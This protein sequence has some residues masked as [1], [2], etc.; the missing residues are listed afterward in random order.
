MIMKKSKFLT[1]VFSMLPGA[2]HMYIG[3]MKTG[4]SFMAAFFFLIFL[5]SWL[6]IGPLLFVL[7]LIW[8]YSFFD[9]ANRASLDDDKLLLLEDKYLFSLDKLVKLDKDIFEKRRLATGVLLLLLGVYLVADNIMNI[10]RQYIPNELYS[11]MNQFMRQ[12]PQVIIGVAI[13]ALGVKLIQGKK[14]ECEK[15]A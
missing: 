7:P 5:S 10:L 12:A 2:G 1:F 4:V 13:V 8:F 9:C 11:I 6:S 14:R 15:D 3:F